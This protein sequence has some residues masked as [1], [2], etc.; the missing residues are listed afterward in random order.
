MLQQQLSLG[1]KFLFILSS[2][3]LLVPPQYNRYYYCYKTAESGEPPIPSIEGQDPLLTGP[4]AYR[5][6]KVQACAKASTGRGYRYFA[7]YKGGECLS[8]PDAEKTYN[9]YGNKVSTRQYCYRYCWWGWC[10]RCYSY[11]VYCGNGYGDSWKMN[12]Y[13][14]YVY[15]VE[16]LVRLNRSFFPRYEDIFSKNS[17]AFTN[18]SSGLQSSLV[19]EITNRKICGVYNGTLRFFRPDHNSSYIIGHYHFPTSFQNITYI[20]D[21]MIGLTLNDFDAKVMALHQYEAQCFGS[22]YVRVSMSLSSHLNNPTK[23]RKQDT[24]STAGY[25]SFYCVN[26]PKKNYTW[27]VA[28]L[29]PDNVTV[30]NFTTVSSSMSWSFSARSL[31]YGLYFVQ[32]S[33]N[34]PMSPYQAGHAIGF[35]EIEPGPLYVYIANGYDAV[36]TENTIITLDG[37]DTYDPDFFAEKGNFGFNMLIANDIHK[38]W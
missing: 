13:N 35:L 3:F 25:V 19:E 6:K 2:F 8:G 31:P 21:K 10:Y 18:A 30:S 9:K 23:H 7:L 20:A 24:T 5:Q 34:T 4:V 28:S 26:P 33:V 12:V 16:L 17:Q 37:S 15:D 27:E 38:I 1:S 22:S 32:L 11:L 14:V 36:Y 29:G